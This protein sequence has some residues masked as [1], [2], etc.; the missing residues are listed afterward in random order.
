MDSDIQNQIA[1]N[2]TSSSPFVTADD[3]IYFR[4]TDNKL[5]RV[6]S[7][8]SG[9]SQ[10]GNNTA[11]STPFV[12]PDGWVWFQGT[13][14][15]L[16]KVFNNGT[17][18]S[19]PGA[20]DTTSSPT[21]VGDWVYF[22]GKNN[23]LFRMNTNGS[24]QSHIG[25]NTTK[26]TPFVTPDGWVWF[27]GTDDHLY[28][29]FNDGSQLSRPGANDTGS[30]PTV[31]GNWVYFQ[32]KD[33]V[34]FRMNTGGSAQSQIGK[35]TTKS[36]PFVTAE[37]WVYFQGTDDHLYRVFNDGTQLTRPG[38]NDTYS[39]PV[40]GRVEIS[41]G[42]VGEWIYFQ[43]V[44]N[45]LTRL[46]QP[47]D[48]VATGTMRPKYYLLSVLYSPPG[49]NGGKSASVVDYSSGSSTGTTTSTS[50]SFKDGI[51]VSASVGFKIPLASSGQSG[52]DS[53]S[54]GA[55]AQF[56][57]S[58]TTTD[59]TKQD[60][61]KSQTWDFKVQGPGEDGIN[62]DNDVFLLMLNPLLTASI[63]PGNNILW[64]MGVDGEIMDIKAPFVGWLKN[65]SLMAKVAPGV[66]QALDAAG[67]TAT[68]YAQILSANP[69]ANGAGSIDPNRFVP[70]PQSFPYQPPESASGSAVLSTVNFQNTF[71]VSSTHTVQNQYGVSVSISA[72]LNL[73]IFSASLKV[74]GSMEWT[75]TNSLGTSSESL[76]S[77]SATVGG[78]AIGFSGPSDVVVYWDTIYNSF[79]F[80]FP[81]Q[82]S[83]AS[84]TLLDS[85]GSPVAHKPV[86]L[87]AGGH[88]FKT[89]TND[90]GQ[91]RF[92]GA[93]G[94]DGSLAVD[95]QNL[96]VA[97]GSGAAQPTLR[98][99]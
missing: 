64:A 84:G 39:T 20:N 66:K 40:V 2:T 92:Y 74:T 17:Q 12:T 77:A 55:S 52:K 5:Y 93:P 69:F 48:P 57:A 30:S 90:R 33:N 45:K 37:G 82:P 38:A 15:K 27:Q 25:K 86:T 68:D 81:S 76:Q 62:H 24:A 1:N 31:V 71:T 94:G 47:V 51:N 16:W 54:L 80:A 78:P 4:G 13:D 97:V 53:Y 67:L 83:T 88:T 46:F 91:Y 60:I 32:G 95:G 61:K 10:I 59:T 56:S 23:E 75:N 87:T 63:Y 70:I 99:R 41:E 19:R 96:A 50:S 7:D 22:R 44:G 29:V 9:L 79:M 65:P 8:G 36:T 43:S 14:D 35:N 49:T 73:G 85:A 34:L 6:N 98:L 21:V 89:V 18:L 58:S 42:T 3:V 26:S 28:R 11:K 72:G